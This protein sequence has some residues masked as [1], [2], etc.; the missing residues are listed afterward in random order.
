MN[1]DEILQIQA[2]LISALTKHGQ[3]LALALETSNPENAAAALGDLLGSVDALRRSL[4]EPAY[5]PSV[6]DTVWVLGTIESMPATVYDNSIKV[7]FGK[8]DWDTHSVNTNETS[9][10]LAEGAVSWQ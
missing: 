1:N 4:P 10:K 3:R 6:G 7:R 9:L 2:G 8:D 5:E